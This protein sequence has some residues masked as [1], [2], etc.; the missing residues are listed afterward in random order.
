[1]AVAWDPLHFSFEAW[2]TIEASN[3]GEY[4]AAK[5]LLLSM[6]WILRSEEVSAL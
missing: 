4:K 2:I 3:Q 1:L 5:I 6:R